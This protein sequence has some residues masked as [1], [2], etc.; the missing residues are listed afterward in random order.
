MVI[1]LTDDEDHLQRQRGIIRKYRDDY[2]ALWQ[3]IVAVPPAT[4]EIAEARRAIVAAADVGRA[5]TEAFL[6]AESSGDAA[7]AADVLASRLIPSHQAWF[8][9]LEANS[10]IRR[11]EAERQVG[12]VLAQKQQAAWL[13]GLLALA[14][15]VLS[16]GI[17]WRVS[18]A[19]QA[20]LGGEPA[21]VRQLVTRI[22]DGDF[23]TAIAVREGD[24]TSLVAA[25]SRM[26]AELKRFA[27]A[28]DALIRDHAAGDTD[29][30]IA[31]RDFHGAYGE[32]AKGVN[33]LVSLH[34]GVSDHVLDV[35]GRY[36]VGDFARDC[37]RLPG[38]Q[39][40]ITEAVDT[41]KAN[42]GRMRDDVLRLAQAAAAGDFSARGD[43]ASFDFAFREIVEALNSLMANAERGLDDVGQVL[44][45]LA[46]GDLTRTMASDHVGAFATLR[47]DV[48]RTV[49]HLTA[50]VGG[51]HAASAAIDTAATEI[52]SGNQDLSH[53]SEQQAANLEETA[54]SLEELTT[55]VRQNADN[56]Q[57]ANALA[58][59]AR[60][61]ATQGG[62][63]MSDVITT[64]DGINAASQRIGDIIGVIDG[65]AFQTNI[66]ALNAAVEAARA[67]EQGRGFA[68]VAS[69]VRALAQRSAAAAKEIKQL[70]DDSGRQVGEGSALVVR[71]G[72]TMREIVASVQKV[73]DILAEISA[74]TSEQSIGI[75]QVST[76][77]S[78]IDQNTQQNVALVEEATAVAHGLQEQAASLTRAVS[79]FRLAP[80]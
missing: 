1:A 79:V 6:A 42:L 66:L 20:Q 13:I 16:A 41:V 63:V 30:R 18:L 59:A 48:Q 65:I 72:D 17:A 53:R 34:I 38:Q 37:D 57:Q 40:R 23:S 24:R 76:A 75:A 49:T 62:E 4:P 22:A 25:A 29:R 69:E 55:T 32:L 27:G 67:G 74:A 10:T 77:V 39:R 12:D 5:A 9:A 8:D 73:G 54:A 15:F 11:A 2:D 51:I 35:I 44:A 78:Q 47:D 64:M 21:D 52:A 14:A 58:A 43:A 45:A 33:D 68:V 80:A 61:V 28:L 70:I 71:A 50:I 36:A 31:D 46:R 26:Q 60:Q 56:V 19:L 7:L 3:A